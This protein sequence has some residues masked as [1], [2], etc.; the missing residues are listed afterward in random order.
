[1]RLSG[2]YLVFLLVGLYPYSAWK[3]R[4]RRVSRGTTFPRLTVYRQT[5][6]AQALLSAL[7][8]WVALDN[9]LVLF[10]AWRP[11]LMAIALGAGALVLIVGMQRVPPLKSPDTQRRTSEIAPRTGKEQVMYVGMI[12]LAA[13]G[14]EIMYRGALFGVIAQATGDWWTA[15]L[16]SAAA[17]GLAHIYQGWRAVV[18][19]LLIG[20]TSQAV[21]LYSGTLYVV[22]A[23]HFVYDF[24]MGR[25]HSRRARALENANTAPASV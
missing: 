15:A 13:L 24:M 25:K 18:I 22:M 17:F 20:L 23:M 4:R 19:V 1:M 8:V 2:Y 3:S 14:E 11:T 6:I 21:V 9:H 12:T 10:A 5:M 7:A 16:V